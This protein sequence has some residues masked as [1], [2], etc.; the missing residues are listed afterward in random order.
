M[1]YLRAQK[2]VEEIIDQQEMLIQRLQPKSSLAEHER[3]HLPANPT[4]GG[5]KVNKAEE[6][7][8]S[9]EQL[10]IKARLAEARAVLNNRKILLDLKEEEL[11]KSRDIFNMIYTLKWVD[12]LKSE[13]IIEETGYSRSQV[14][15]IINQLERQLE[16]SNDDEGTA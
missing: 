1:D 7:V 5:Q 3:E 6:Y 4:G 2:A 14:Y 13:L 10:M 15:N 16:R 9:M 12:N 11:R 8:I